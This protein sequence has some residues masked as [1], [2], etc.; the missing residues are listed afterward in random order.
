MRACQPKRCEEER[1]R[2]SEWERAR[3]WDR[4]THRER[5]RETQRE[6]PA[7]WLFFLYVFFSLLPLGLPYVNW[8]SQE[9]C[10]FSLRSSLWSLDLPLF[11][12]CLLVT[13]I[14]GSF[15]LSY[16]PNTPPPREGRPSSLEMGVLRSFWLLPA[17]LGQWG[18]LGLPLLIVSGLRVLTGWVMFSVAGWSFIYPYWTGTAYCSL[19]TW[20]ETKRV[21]QL[22]VYGAI[23]S[24][25]NMVITRTSRGISRLQ[26]S[27]TSR[28][29][30]LLVQESDL[31]PVCFGVQPLPSCVGSLV[32]S[33]EILSPETRL[34]GCSLEWH[35]CAVLNRYLRSPRGSQVYWVSS[36]V[37][38]HG[39]THDWGAG[40]AR[41]PQ[42]HPLPLTC[43]QGVRGNK[44]ERG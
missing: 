2:E 32:L 41:V 30:S 42:L 16:L 9:C 5:D 29:K 8:A 25:I 38:F 6:P 27:I 33:W 3:Q 44:K 21:R 31:S 17:E 18:A 1:A 37:F 36:S 23:I 40:P 10:L 35:S 22:I 24:S 26:I 19:L 39:L 15:L 13:A 34:W 14:L 12:F 7:L 4:D 28:I 43:S 20:A 11:C